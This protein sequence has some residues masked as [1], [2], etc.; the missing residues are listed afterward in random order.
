MK[1]KTFWKKIKELLLKL[2]HVFHKRYCP[3]C[4][5]KKEEVENE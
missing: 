4:K 5:E 2:I 1:N 3:E